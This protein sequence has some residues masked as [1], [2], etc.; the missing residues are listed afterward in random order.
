MFLNLKCNFLF[1][2]KWMMNFF[3]DFCHWT[4]LNLQKNYCKNWFS[5]SKLQKRLFYKLSQIF[6]FPH[7]FWFEKIFLAFKC[8]TLKKR[9]F[10]ENRKSRYFFFLAT[11]KHDKHFVLRREIFFFIKN[12]SK[13]LVFVIVNWSKV[14]TENE[15]KNFIKNIFAFHSPPKN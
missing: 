11:Y 8:T 9:N 1:Y 2:L 4:F 13:D 15:H 6:F 5:K 10:T 12:E 3:I 7:F 14:F